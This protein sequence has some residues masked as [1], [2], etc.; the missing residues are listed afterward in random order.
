MRRAFGFNSQELHA[1]VLSFPGF[2]SNTR[3]GTIAPRPGEIL[4]Q[5]EDAP[6]G[7]SSLQAGIPRD[8]VPTGYYADPSYRA[9]L[10]ERQR[11]L[12][13][14]AVLQEP[15]KYSIPIVMAAMS[16]AR[17]AFQKKQAAVAM[18]DMASLG[19]RGFSTSGAGGDAIDQTNALASVYVQRVPTALHALHGAPS[20]IRN[21]FLPRQNVAPS[22]AQFKPTM[23][24]SF[25]E[26][27]AQIFYTA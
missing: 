21:R 20:R 17:S 8:G 2:W 13:D 3:Q 26:N 24:P 7:Y 5:N 27:G 12:Y 22:Y 10:P 16:S 23:M 14:Y 9:R 15:Q 1:P 18:A 11:N 6:F 25:G 19:T 4:V